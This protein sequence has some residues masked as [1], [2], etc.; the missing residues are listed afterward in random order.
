MRF[1]LT[2]KQFEKAWKRARVAAGYPNT[3]SH[4]LRHGEAS[5]M[6]NAGIDLFTVGGGAR[7]Q[8]GRVDQAVFAP[9]HRK[10]GGRSREDRAED[11]GAEKS[12][13]G[14]KNRHPTHPQ[15]GSKKRRTL[16]ASVV[17]GTGLEP[18]SC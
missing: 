18:V 1:T 5:E 16:A 12:G 6:I 13:S 3:K 11:E 14:Q 2:I 4:D 8:V 10:I 9:D 15:E 17:P 7:A